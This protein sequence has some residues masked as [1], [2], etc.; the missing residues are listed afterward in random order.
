MSKNLRQWI[1]EMEEGLPGEFLRTG[2]RI[3][4]AKYECSALL[5]QFERKSAFPTMFFENVVDV[6]GEA[7]PF[8]LLMNAFATTPKIATALGL[9]GASRRQVMEQYNRGQAAPRDVIKV[10]KAEAPVKE[11]IW[12]G[13]DVNLKKLPIPRVNEMD[14]G[15]Y[16][17][18]IIVGRH[19]QT[20]RYN[21]SWNR[22]MV[23]DATHMGIW[24]SPRH[25]WSYFMKAEELGKSV[26]VAVVL[27]HHPAF[28][29]VGA[30][31]TKMDQDEYRVAGGVMGEAVRVVDSEVLGGELVVPADA[32]IVLEGEIVADKRTIE[33]PFGEFT[34]Y[35][36]PQR[37]SWLLE[38]KAVTARKDG[39]IIGVFGAHQDNLNAHYPIQADIYANLRVTMPNV[40]DLSWVDAGAPLSMV[41]AMQKKSEG[42]PLR[43][44]MNAFAQSNFL[45][46]ITVVDDDIDPGDL[47][48]VGWAVA[49]RVQA[50]RD[51]NILKGMQGQVLDPSLEHEIRGAGMVIDATRPL[52][53]P[54][55]VKAQPPEDVVAGMD[56]LKYFPGME[57]D[58]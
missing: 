26:P 50:D 34:G 20:G 58:K 55:S 7:S 46:H 3:N 12:T 2:Q 5:E 24:M 40:V 43:A 16:L 27:G 19:P 32:E 18:P 47:R 23:I 14:G 51:V 28:Y 49:T 35:E 6:E 11:V 33:G 56:A 21:I 25:L 31:L 15:P 10:G 30:G 13:K 22:C 9:K 45:K 38:V 39:I 8:R 17:S 42:E 52:D 44:A 41:I 57:K 29:L 4:P 53:R 54:Y 48:Q 36:G 37:L 1:A